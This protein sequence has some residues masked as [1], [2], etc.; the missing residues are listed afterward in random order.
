MSE[1]TAP[2]S[3]TVAVTADAARQDG[4]SIHGDLG[5]HRLTDKGIQW[6]VLPTYTDPIP[7][8]DLAG[9]QAVLSLGHISFDSR[10]LDHTPDLQLV[11]R[12]GAGYETIDLD[13]C[14]RAGVV[15][16][17]TPDA[18]RKPLATAGLTLLLALSH[19]LLAKDRLT[20][21]ANWEGR[22]H[23]R[24]APLSGQTV[25]IVGFGSVG[26]ELAKLLV[27]LGME[28]I[29]NNRSGRNPEASALGV[30]LVGLDELLERSDY[31]VLCAA[32]TPATE[33]LIDA[34]A[35]AKMKSG[36]Y[37]VNIGR[38]KLVDTD[39]LRDALRSGHLAGAGLD[40]FEPEPLNPDDEIL[41]MD[42]VVLSPHS[43]CWTEDFTRDVSAGAIASIIAVAEG[44]RPSDVLNPEVFDTAAFA[45]K[46]R[47]KAA[48]VMPAS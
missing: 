45:A 2:A 48:V 21:T 11:A 25:G 18:I 8:A 20:R 15:V 19:K 9:V 3:F 35:F 16:T 47:R 36:A 10:T 12:F 41:S 39:A 14:T 40:V 29:G 23:Y 17:N 46:R 43:L 13:A 31:V 38:G 37:L 26:A 30:D 44:Q 4:S 1:D 42:N 34:S 28:V 27:P 33:R 32:L 6:R 7:P 22:E 5:L 24:G